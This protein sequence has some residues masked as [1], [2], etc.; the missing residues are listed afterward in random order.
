MNKEEEIYI[1]P[2]KT[3]YIVL[4][5]HLDNLELT[6]HIGKIPDTYFTTFPYAEYYKQLEQ[7][8]KQLKDNWNELKEYTQEL[9]NK[10][11]WGCFGARKV[12]EKMQ[13]FE[14]GSEE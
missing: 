11:S 4:T 14:K 9:Y 5:T 12:L 6:K 2:P 3:N 8:N 7:E 1:E 10:P 13:E